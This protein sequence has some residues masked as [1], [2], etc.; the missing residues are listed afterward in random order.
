M[1]IDIFACTD[2][3]KE[4]DHNED[5]FILCPDLSHP[6]WEKAEASVELSEYGSLLVVA[7]GM[8]GANAGEVA[9]NT[10]LDSIKNYFTPSSVA[11]AVQ[12][13]KLIEQF[14]FDAIQAANI[15]LNEVM[16]QHPETEGMGTTIVL[17][18]ILK[19]MAYIAWCGDSRC[20]VFNQ[21]QELK[22]LT[23]DHSY[24]QE[25]VD[26]GDITEQEAFTH[27]DNNIITHGLGDFIEGAKPDIINY[28]YQPGDLFVLC[29]DGLCGYCTHD[30]LRKTI[31]KTHFHTKECCNAL[32]QLALESGGYDNICIALAK[33]IDNPKGNKTSFFKRLFHSS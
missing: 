12:S 31:K 11:K 5:A 15:A 24:V 8:G 20:Y 9:S 29:S 13:P 22:A 10:A 2:N 26:R 28:T 3:G 33:V 7:D 30:T 19:P 17:C 4:R 21:K 23:K 25:L 27:P 1:R 18:W 32:L 14:L 6:E 16:T